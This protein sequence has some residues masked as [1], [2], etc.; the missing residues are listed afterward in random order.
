MEHG[1]FSAVLFDMD[2]VLMDSMPIHAQAWIEALASEGLHVTA[3]EVY[4]HE[5]E[6]GI[7]ALS[8]FLIE[9]G[10]TAEEPLLHR[11]LKGKEE[12]FKHLARVRPFPGV[13]E[14]LQDLSQ[15]GK[16]LAVVT[17]TARHELNQLLPAEWL[18]MFE[19]IVTGDEVKRGKPDPEPY[20]RGLDKLNLTAD[21]AIVVENAPLGIRAAKAANL[22]CFAIASTLACEDL[23][24][25]DACFLTIPD[26]HNFLK[27]YL[28]NA[29]IF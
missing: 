25:S 12:R 23:H 20:R 21:Q 4:A 29:K 6:S 10:V 8:N 9:Q 27:P 28:K 13:W 22:R 26:F 17:G 14:L 24:L 7:S 2:G 5:G 18:P 11:L 3:E 15:S 16:R 19:T 1:K